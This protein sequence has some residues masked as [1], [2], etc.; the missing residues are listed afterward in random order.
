MAPKLKLLILNPLDPNDTLQYNSNVLRMLRELLHAARIAGVE[1]GEVDAGAGA[2]NPL[3]ELTVAGYDGVVIPGS[4]ASATEATPWVVAL[5]G[6]IRK[7]YASDV[8][9]LGIC[10]GHQAMAHAL[11]GCVHANPAGSLRVTER[12]RALGFGARDLALQYSHGDVV[13]RLPPCA[14]AVG[15]SWSSEDVA[16]Y[17]RGGVARG[18]SF[19]AHPEFSTPTGVRILQKIIR[20]GRQAK[21][22]T[23]ARLRE[24]PA[25]ATDAAFAFRAA[26]ATL[27]P[28]AVR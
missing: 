6:F 2:L 8:P 22:L 19:Q 24:R 21:K 10:Y 26:L 7:L 12:G 1:L 14:Q 5:N 11:G 18:I 25:E 20:D 27:F 4:V 28:D 17:E 16:V 9:M 13:S 3:D 23:P 15:R